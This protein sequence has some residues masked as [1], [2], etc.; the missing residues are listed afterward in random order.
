ML[1]S[2]N[3]T[4]RMPRDLILNQT[5]PRATDTWNT[6]IVT[7]WP[8]TS[9]NPEFRTMS[10]PDFKGSTHSQTPSRT[11][12]PYSKCYPG[13]INTVK[14]YISASFSPPEM[15]SL[16]LSKVYPLRTNL[17]ASSSTHA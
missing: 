13:S 7:F 11:C 4:S 2:Q 16:Y 1:L 15:S 6:E 8:R 9:G 5:C 14:A 17:E 3:L 12:F 10:L